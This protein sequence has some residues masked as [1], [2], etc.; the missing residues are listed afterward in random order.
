[1]HK[2]YTGDIKTLLNQASLENYYTDF[3]LPEFGMTQ[4]PI[5]NRHVKTDPDNFIHLFS[6]NNI[7]YAL[8]FD[9]YPSG[10]SVEK[11]TSVTPVQLHNGESILHVDSPYDT[12]RENVTGYFMLF[13]VI[14]DGAFEHLVD[15]IEAAY[16]E[17]QQRWRVESSSFVDMTRDILQLAE[18]ASQ[19]HDKSSLYAL[20]NIIEAISAVGVVNNGVELETLEEYTK[21]LLDAEFGY[22]HFTTHDR[23]RV[24]SE[25]YGTLS[26]ELQNTITIQK[27]ESGHLGQT[28]RLVNAMYAR[29]DDG[30]TEGITATVVFDDEKITYPTDHFINEELKKY[31]SENNYISRSNV[32]QHM[33]DNLGEYRLVAGTVHVRD[34]FRRE[35]HN[36]TF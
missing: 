8:A 33:P 18:T 22:E 21:I 17:L 20:Q 5:W 26:K 24:A 34:V 9:D 13:K 30:M 15:Y 6:V 2:E 16:E 4:Q 12:Y 36:I 3:V 10:F 19:N 1:M 32:D 14:N 11:D 28:V 29:I 35:L 7:Q 31:F 23:E 25:I 27:Y